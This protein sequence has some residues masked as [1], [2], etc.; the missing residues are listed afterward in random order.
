MIVPSFSNPWQ[1]ASTHFAFDLLR[2]I[3]PWIV[4]G[5]LI[6]VAIAALVPERL[7]TRYRGG[8]SWDAHWL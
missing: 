6:G 1:R 4:A 3:G 7:N 8:A 5:V 2:E